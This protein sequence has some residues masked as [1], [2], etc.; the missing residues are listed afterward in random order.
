ME[1]P[2]QPMRTEAASA[3][4]YRSPYG[5]THPRIQLLTVEELLHGKRLDYPAPTQTNVTYKRAPRVIRDEESQ[6]LF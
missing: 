6:K 2:T 5:T 3:G 1:E 4:F